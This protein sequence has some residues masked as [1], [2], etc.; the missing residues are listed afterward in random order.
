MSLKGLL[1]RIAFKK[2]I[3]VSKEHNVYRD[4]STYDLALLMYTALS[5]PA[6]RNLARLG[7]MLSPSYFSR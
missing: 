3:G 1:S 4:T 6:H 7:N 2:D 5:S